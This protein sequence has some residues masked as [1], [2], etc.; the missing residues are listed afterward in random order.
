[1]NTP[2]TRGEFERNFALLHQQLAE[3][4]FRFPIDY[5]MDSIL[6]VRYLP[7]GRIDFLSVDEM[8]RLNANTTGHFTEE[9]FD[10]LK[11]RQDNPDPPPSVED[12]DLPPIFCKESSD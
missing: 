12:D 4:R 3:G 6:R 1:M 8:A 10:E 11:E 2:R 9:F 5:P 7:N